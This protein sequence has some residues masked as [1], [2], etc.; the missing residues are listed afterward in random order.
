MSYI[1]IGVHGLS[2]K[3]DR[4]ILAN[5]WKRAICEGIANIQNLDEASVNV[6]FGMVDWIDLYYDS[7]DSNPQNRYQKAGENQIKRY[8]DNWRDAARSRFG[9][10]VD[11][12]LEWLKKRG[13]FT[14][15]ADKVLERYIK[16]LDRYYEDENR[17]NQTRI[18]VAD[19]IKKNSRRRIMLI[20][21]SMGSIITYDVLRQLGRENAQQRI[22]HYITIGSPLGLPHVQNKILE[23]FGNVRTPSI[24][25]NW[26]NFSDKLDPVALDNHLRRDFKPNSR[27]VR[28]E[29]DIILNDWGDINHKS[30]GY[31]RC[32]EVAEQIARFI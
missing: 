24:V 25:D 12:P 21:H 1:I 17:R 27:G 18:L 15:A 26:S 9:D 31:L 28:P 3:P 19:A 30:Y 22:E 7:R 4:D 6:E 13:L 32:P 29:D 20:G 10:V 23:E 16:D 11:R 14:D 5:G 2:P 8:Q